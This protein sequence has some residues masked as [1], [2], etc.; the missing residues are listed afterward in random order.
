M[1][2]YTSDPDSRLGIQW[3]GLQLLPPLKDARFGCGSFRFWNVPGVLKGDGERGVR[4]RIV[5]CERS[6]CQGCSDG[7]LQAAGIAQGAHQAVVRVVARFVDS[8]GG[9]KG[10]CRL[11]GCALCEQVHAFLAKLVRGLGI[12]LVH[13]VLRIMAEGRLRG[14]ALLRRADEEPYGVSGA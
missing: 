13:A 9:A 5:G 3:G 7:L 12:R 14:T 11:G 1:L 2:P 4:Q 8:D 10:L 6:Q